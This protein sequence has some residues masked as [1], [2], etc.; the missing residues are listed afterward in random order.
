MNQ[1]MVSVVIAGLLVFSSFPLF[2]SEKKPNPFSFGDDDSETISDPKQ[3]LEELQAKTKK[4]KNL[5][6]LVIN[7]QTETSPRKC[8]LLHIALNTAGQNNGTDLT[9]GDILN[10]SSSW[11]P[12]QS[13]GND[14]SS[15]TPTEDVI[16]NKI[17]APELPDDTRILK[18]PEEKE[19]SQI[20][21]E[22]DV[23]RDLETFGADIKD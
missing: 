2:C 20:Q 21:T 9:V 18:T 6:N 1:R 10:D 8:G 16:L 19:P 11:V 14:K 22:A 13:N 5:K 7:T 15:H 4:T 17:F 3:Y 23:L 12:E